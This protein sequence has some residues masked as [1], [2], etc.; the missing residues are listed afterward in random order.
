[1]WEEDDAVRASVDALVEE[2]Y[3]QREY[4]L[5]MLE[6]MDTN[7]TGYLSRAEMKRGLDKLGVRLG[8]GALSDVVRSC[9]ALMHGFVHC[10]TDTLT[11][12]CMHTCMLAMQMRAFDANGDGRVSYR[13]FYKVLSRERAAARRPSRGSLW[14]EDDAVRAA[15]D[16]LCEELYDR[17][18]Y[19]YELLERMDTNKT[20]YLSRAEMKRG[21]DKLGLRLSAADLSHVMRG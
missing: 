16:S 8:A 6:R 7:G 17:R 21:L 12:A 11:I 2:L 4:V 10:F 5:E 9:F 13:E 18:E 3:E 1:M 15:V 14:E 19:V 20:G